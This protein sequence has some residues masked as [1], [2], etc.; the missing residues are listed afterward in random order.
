MSDI[1]PIDEEQISLISSI[2]EDIMRLGRAGLV[3]QYVIYSNLYVETRHDTGRAARVM[4]AEQ[5]MP[6]VLALKPL[7]G[8]DGE[9]AGIVVRALNDGIVRALMR[10]KIAGRDTIGA[11]QADEALRWIVKRWTNGEYD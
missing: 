5:V 3:G 10:A 1:P 7:L 8:T 9:K 6:L 2:Y 4:R 11:E